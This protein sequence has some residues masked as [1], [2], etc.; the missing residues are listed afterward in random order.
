MKGKSKRGKAIIGIAM[1][2]IMAASVFAAIAPMGSAVS[3]GDNF[4]YIGADQ[5]TQT[6][7]VGQNVQFN[8]TQPSGNWSTISAVTVQKFEDGIWY[9]YRGPWTDGKAYNVNWDPDLTLRATDGLGSNTSLSVQDPTVPLKL[10]VGTKEVDSVAKGTN[11][12]IDVGG[13]NLFDNDVVKLI[14]KDSDGT[15]IRSE[16]DRIGRL[17]TFDPITVGELRVLVI[18]TNEWDVDDYT[19]KIETKP[20]N[21]CG[22]D[23]ESSVKELAIVKGKIEVT[24]D[25]TDVV[26]LKSV[27]ITVT[28]VEGD[29]IEVECT[30]TDAVFEA[31]KYNTP[32][33]GST[34]WTV[35]GKYNKFEDTIDAD[36]KREYSVYFTDTGSYKIKATVTGLPGDPRVGDDDDV[37]IT[38][39]AKG[40]TFDIPHT[41]AVGQKITIKGTATSGTYVDVWVDDELYPKL[42]DL[43][44]D[45][46]EF[47]K[48]VVTT[49]VGMGVPDETLRLKAW[50]DDEE[51]Y[52]PGDEPPSGSADG[53]D[54]IRLVRPGLTAELSQEVVALEDDFYVRGTAEGSDEVVILAV[55]PSGGG[56]E[57]LTTGEKGITVESASVST[58]DD[59]FEKKLSVDE[60]AQTGYHAIVVLSIG[61]DDRWGT[62]D[63]DM[64]LEDVLDEGYGIDL[65]ELATYST[66]TQEQLIEIILDLVTAAGADDLVWTETLKVEDVK[67]ELDLIADVGIGEPLVVTG[68][69][70]RKEGFPIVITVKGPIELESL[71]AYVENGTFNKTF[72]TS[73][74]VVGTYTVK[75]DDGDGNVDETTVWIG[76]AKP[77]PTPEVEVTPTPEVEITPTPVVSP[78][79]PEETPTPTPEPPGFEAVFAIAGL[80]AVAYLVLRKRR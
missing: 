43:I 33:E 28:G 56:G 30:S 59:T 78:T 23:A 18:D 32:A 52:E 46:G 31:G 69:T 25:K 50:I 5:P 22:L 51:E 15:P 20:E 16:K 35:I 17:Q 61:M 72:D 55:P 24:A 26:E 80:L 66:K 29:E 47:E 71:T 1:A 41:A 10:K 77:T 3:K 67:I 60:D 68:T 2:A 37:D 75:A 48:E 34:K 44:I 62:Y 4:N 8:E 49:D 38:V 39:S 70:N 54:T 42:N 9:D 36:G 53:E 19:F 11:F 79:P 27:K 14:I 12:T 57:A 64:S 40:V 45:D 73:D 63:E 13:I 65:D 21:A 74:A 58:T 6:V 7:L 76:E